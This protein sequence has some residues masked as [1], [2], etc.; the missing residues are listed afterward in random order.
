MLITGGAT[1][2]LKLSEASTAPFV[3]SLFQELRNGRSNRSF[4]LAACARPR[5]ERR[6]LLA[7]LVF[8][9]ARVP[10][11]VRKLLRGAIN[12]RSS[13]VGRVFVAVP[14]SRTRATPTTFDQIY[15]DTVLLLDRAGFVWPGNACHRAGRPDCFWSRNAP[16]GHP[17]GYFPRSGWISNDLLSAGELSEAGLNKLHIPLMFTWQRKQVS[18]RRQHLTP[19]GRVCYRH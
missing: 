10:S 19:P 11:S 8:E 12:R 7:R 2:P 1:Q 17:G 14:G 4:G 9:S 16:L 5:G 18:R 15:R 3:R 13:E 6:G